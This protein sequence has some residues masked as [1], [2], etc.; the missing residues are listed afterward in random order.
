MPTT[1]PRCAILAAEFAQAIVDVMIAEA[2]EEAAARGAKLSRT[3]RVSGAYEVPLV[4]D[5]IL[6]QPDVDVLIV[7]GFI[8]R[9]QTQHGEVMGHVVHGALIDLEL[10]H[11]KPVG[12]G[13]IGPGATIE[14]AEARKVDYARAAVRAAVRNWHIVCDQVKP[15]A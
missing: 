13:I 8:E 15:M 6:A 2:A 9:G 12:I 7:L 1:Q 14:Q 10:K 3:V 11:K 5:A 4:A